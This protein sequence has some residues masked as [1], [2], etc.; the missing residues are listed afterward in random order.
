M[1]SKNC[2]FTLPAMALFSVFSSQV[3]AE[4]SLQ[5]EALPPPAIAPTSTERTY[6]SRTVYE[7][8]FLPGV[9]LCEEDE[10]DYRGDFR[11]VNCQDEEVINSVST[12]QNLFNV[13]T[14]STFI[15]N[16]SIPNGNILRIKFQR[17]VFTTNP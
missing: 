1:N 4:E 11:R 3:F 12:R 13:A 14:P 17:K 2:N 6:E 10:V 16:T 8:S 7:S 15:D 5:N 9:R